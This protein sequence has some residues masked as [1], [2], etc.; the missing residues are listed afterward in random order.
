MPCIVP[1]SRPNQV[2]KTDQSVKELVL[3]LYRD[4]LLNHASS[5]AQSLTS[6]LSALGI[7]QEVW[8]TEE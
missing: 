4:T 7:P 1:Y 8:S 2:R 3:Y 6:P 5:H